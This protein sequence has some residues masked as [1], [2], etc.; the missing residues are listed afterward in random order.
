MRVVPCFVLIAATF[1]GCS[2]D[3]GAC[4]MTAATQV[5]YAA[6]GTPYYAGQ[7]LVEYACAPGV[8]NPVYA[9]NAS[10]R[11]PPFGLTFDLGPLSASSMPSNVGALRDR[12]A[13]VHD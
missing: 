11:G 4:D 2:E 5:V 12:L 10:R 9:A 13:K 1:A 7:G 8:C 6:D 3:L